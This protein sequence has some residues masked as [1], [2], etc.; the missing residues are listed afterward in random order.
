MLYHDSTG[1][2]PIGNISWGSWL[3]CVVCSVPGELLFFFFALC[4]LL[5]VFAFGERSADF[6]RIRRPLGLAERHGG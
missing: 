5:F 2:V 1:I 4:K 6:A 3:W